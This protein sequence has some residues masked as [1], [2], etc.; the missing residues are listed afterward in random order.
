MSFLTRPLFNPVG[1]VTTPL[2]LKRIGKFIWLYIFLLSIAWLFVWLFTSRIDA[3]EKDLQENFIID[4]Y[5]Y[6]FLGTE[7]ADAFQQSNSYT[8]TELVFAYSPNP[9]SIG[10]TFLNASYALLGVGPYVSAAIQSL[11]FAITA[12]VVWPKT[13]FTKGL[14]FL[15]LCGLSPYLLIPSKESF[16]LIGYMLFFA[17]WF[18]H[19]RRMTLVIV[20]I[21]IMGVARPGAVLLLLVALLLW[22]RGPLWTPFKFLSIPISYLFFRSHVVSTSEFEQV[23]SSG[24]PDFF[25]SV[26]PIGVCLG[27]EPFEVVALKRLLLTIGFPLKWIFD[28]LQS[29]LSMDSIE[30][31]IKTSCVLLLA[32]GISS[33][34]LLKF[35]N[36]SHPANSFA[37]VFM[38]VY[39]MSYSAMVFFQPSRHIA[40]ALCLFLFSLS[41]SR[42]YSSRHQPS[43]GVRLHPAQ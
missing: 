8:L 36:L 23:V 15:L 34:R 2:P 35:K 33:R 3:T 14:G 31:A 41:L 40:L 11:A 21:A 39:A 17:G 28:W 43:T 29:I 26:G 22:R 1:W 19:P 7:I 5:F 12:S 9:Q 27:S 10:I 24:R 32:W 13:F 16:I 38:L 18:L 25:C 42:S 30:I 37:L 4:A 6:M 20:G